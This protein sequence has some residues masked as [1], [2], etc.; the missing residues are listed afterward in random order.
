MRT[1]LDYGILVEKAF[2]GMIRAALRKAQNMVGENLCF[3]MVIDTRHKGITIPKYLKK[4]YP[5]S[6]TLILQH[7]F[8][9]LRVQ[10]NCFSVEL[11]FGGKLEEVSVPFGAILAFS[12]RTSGMELVFDM[13]QA[14]SGSNDCG[15]LYSFGLDY[16]ERAAN[17][18]IDFKN[19]IIEFEDI[20]KR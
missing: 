7:Q 4:Q 19:N 14:D 8:A 12:D 9:N 3:L 1:G 18:D 5:N 6:I 13:L 17:V 10:S 11:N 20:R 15:Y 2:R 16:E